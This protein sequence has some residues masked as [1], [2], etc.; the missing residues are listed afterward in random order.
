MHRTASATAVK[1][2][3]LVGIALGFMAHSA[4]AEVRL[5]HVIGSNMVL[6]RDMR[7]PIWGWA[8]PNE[9]VT[10]QLGEH[11]ATTQADKTTGR[12]QLLLPATPAGGPHEL[13]ISGSNTLTLT[14]ILFGDVWLCSGQSNM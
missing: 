2:S 14:N 3:A 1:L 7:V 10:I 9:T 13:I 11:K 5:P 6:Q 8:E 12:W 4:S